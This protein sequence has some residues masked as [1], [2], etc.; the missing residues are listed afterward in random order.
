MWMGGG[1][2]PVLR[3]NPI[4]PPFMRQ[5][6]CTC[7]KDRHKAPASTLHGPLSLQ[8]GKDD[9]KHCPIRSA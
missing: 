6:N 7:E 5:T 4:R 2:V 8:T 9:P 3:G 1:L